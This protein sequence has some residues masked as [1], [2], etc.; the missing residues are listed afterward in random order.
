[1]ESLPYVCLYRDYLQTL[2]PYNDEERGR[3]FTAMLHYINGEEIPEFTG[4][5]RFIWPTLL[6]QLQ[7]DKQVYEEKCEKNRINGKKGGRPKKQSFSEKETEGFSEEPKKP[8]KKKNE[9]NKKNEK[10]NEN[11]KDNDNETEKDRSFSSLA[12][13]PPARPRF[14][15]PCE[16]EIRDYCLQMGYTFDPMQFMDYYLSNGWMVGKNPMQDWKAAVRSWNVK[17]KERKKTHHPNQPQIPTWT[18]GTTF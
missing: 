4:N 14:I 3:L 2:A 13:K 1:M 8:K 12:D 10:E 5:E 17:E 18:V 6:A 16:E 9:N 7:R 11:E 15:P